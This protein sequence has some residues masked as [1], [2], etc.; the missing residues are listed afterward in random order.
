LENHFREEMSSYHVVGY[1]TLTGDVVVKQTHQG[2]GD[3]TAW[4]RGQSWGLYGYLICYRETKDP[5]Y[6]ETAVKIA[7]FIIPN[8]P[9]DLVP[10]WDYNDPAIPK[11]KK[12]ASAGALIASAFYE[13]GTY[14]DN[15]QRYFDLAD[16]L[17]ATLSSDE[18]LAELS[19]NGGFLLKHSV[20]HMPKNSEVDVPL[21]YA[22]YYYLEAIKRQKELKNK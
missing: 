13:L 16:K 17:L 10:Y 1:D 19:T 11:A 3:E 12:D 21:N 14:V 8:L 2:L 4:A 9:E 15:G 7:D 20:G 18:Y 5:I 6:L 22:D